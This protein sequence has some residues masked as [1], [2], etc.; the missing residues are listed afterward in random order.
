MTT[1]QSSGSCI[2]RMQLFSFTGSRKSGFRKRF[3]KTKKE[4]EVWQFLQDVESQL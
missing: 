2:D 4:R 3:S 1:I